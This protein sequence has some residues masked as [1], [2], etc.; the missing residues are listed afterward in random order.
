[1]D[2]GKLNSALSERFSEADAQLQKTIESL[3]EQVQS[4]LKGVEADL[5]RHLQELASLHHLNGDDSKAKPEA[6]E[7]W[8]LHDQALTLKWPQVGSGSH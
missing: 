1:M 2:A 5:T 4:L 3:Q 7:G 6:L 8:V